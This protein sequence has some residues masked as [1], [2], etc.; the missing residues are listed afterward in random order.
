VRIRCLVTS[1]TRIACRSSWNMPN[2]SVRSEPHVC[3]NFS[4][5]PKYNFFKTR[6]AI[7]EL[8]HAYRRK[9]GSF[10][11]CAQQS[12]GRARN[13]STGLK[14]RTTED[15]TRLHFTSVC[16]R[17]CGKRLR[18]S[19]AGCSVT[20]IPLPAALRPENLEMAS[21]F[22]WITVCV[23]TEEKEKTFHFPEKSNFYF[24]V[25]PNQVQYHLV[26]K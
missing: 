25:L 26:S 13:V 11:W 10:L 18:I 6:S 15:I 9:E 5:I 2:I 22:Q 19:R 23:L 20:A 3:T 4:T 12:C 24:R 16:S 7:I 8:F 1:A 17:S 14:T 21:L